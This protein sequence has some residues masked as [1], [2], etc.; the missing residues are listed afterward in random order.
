MDKQEQ[1][2][3]KL[4]KQRFKSAL[5]GDTERYWENSSGEAREVFRN[6]AI[7]QIVRKE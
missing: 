5:Y 6:L 1:L 7:R 2:V 3:E 4:A